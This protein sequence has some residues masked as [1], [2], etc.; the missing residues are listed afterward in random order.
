MQGTIITFIHLDKHNDSIHPEPMDAA[1]RNIP[2]SFWEFADSCHN[3][4]VPTIRSNAQRI[5]SQ[6][7]ETGQLKT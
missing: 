5:A 1:C 4:L 6:S 2:T 7:A 3:V